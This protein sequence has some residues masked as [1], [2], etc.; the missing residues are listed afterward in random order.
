MDTMVHGARHGALHSPGR[1]RECQICN[2]HV[3]GQTHVP[4]YT[5]QHDTIHLSS[6]NVQLTQGLT[7][8]RL[9]VCQLVPSCLMEQECIPALLSFAV[10]SVCKV[11]LLH[12]NAGKSAWLG[13]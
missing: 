13:V 12:A 6:A 11:Y 1:R 8:F 5:A 2:T 9:G 4:M 3:V 10:M 7:G